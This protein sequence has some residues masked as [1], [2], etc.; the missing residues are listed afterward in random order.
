MAVDAG[1]ALLLVRATARV[2]AVILAGNLLVAARRVRGEE[3]PAQAGH[4]LRRGDGGDVRRAD[5]VTF[6]AFIVSHTIHFICVTLL[7]VATRGGH[8]DA[9][10]ADA[11]LV[12]VGLLFYLACAAVLRVKLRGASGWPRPKDRLIEVW[13]LA[14]IWLAFFQAYVTRP[15]Q[16]WLFPAL[17]I[18]LLYALAR[19]VSASLRSRDLPIPMRTP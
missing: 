9:R 3:G 2:S 12:A 15:L 4:Y 18:V 6:A 1:Q 17:A 19:F 14:A 8:I 13:M 11:L 16:W 5:V 7:I 10:A